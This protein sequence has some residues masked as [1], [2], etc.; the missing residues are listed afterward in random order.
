MKIGNSNPLNTPAPALAA[1]N[2]TAPPVR[3]EATPREAT[4]AAPVNGP[5]TDAADSGSSVQMSETSAALREGGVA[6]ANAEFDTE[7]VQR[8]RQAI[9]DG[10]YRINAEA[11]ADKLLANAQDLLGQIGTGR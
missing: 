11:I 4:P 10:V 1:V 9:S 6:D 7:K 3:Q 8:M 5:P 2:P